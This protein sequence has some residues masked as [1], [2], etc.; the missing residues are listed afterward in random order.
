LRIDLSF[1]DAD[2]Q[3]DFVAI[4]ENKVARI[5]ALMATHHEWD[6]LADMALLTSLQVVVRFSCPILPYDLSLS[7]LFIAY[8]DRAF[9]YWCH[10]LINLVEHIPPALRHSVVWGPRDG[11][12]GPTTIGNAEYLPVERRQLVE[13]IVKEIRE[14]R[15]LPRFPA[16]GLHPNWQWEKAV[17]P[18]EDRDLNDLMLHH[19]LFAMQ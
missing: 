16:R 8:W 13:I 15:R 5:A 12:L 1:S 4:T 11:E 7:E 9:P 3:R 6:F 14:K 2:V 10:R 18:D 19:E 17:Y